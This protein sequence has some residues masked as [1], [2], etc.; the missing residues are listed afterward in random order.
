MT[1]DKNKCAIELYNWLIKWT[2]NN[3][4]SPE[5]IIGII[6]CLKA[7]YLN[8]ALDVVKLKERN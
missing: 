3:N 4:L 6:E 8:K 7:V 1:E 5:E 2:E